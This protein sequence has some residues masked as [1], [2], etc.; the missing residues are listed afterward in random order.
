M[1]PS[2]AIDVT[3]VVPVWDAYVDDRL[4]RALESVRAQDHPSHLIVVDNASSTPI[5]VAD[6]IELLRL[7]QRV[8]VGAA[9]NAGCERAGT[10]W[11]VVWD[12]DD[13]MPPSALSRL[14]GQ[15]RRRPDAVAVFGSI[16][17]GGTGQRF[18]WP[19]DWT[20]RLTTHRG[21]FAFLNA[22]SSLYPTVG[23]LLARGPL[24]AGGGF[25]DVDTGDDWV[26]GASLCLRGP[27]VT[28]LDPTRLYLRHHDSVSS[29]WR[30]YPDLVRHGRLVCDRLRH[31]AATPRALRRALPAVRLLQYLVLF[32]VRP[33]SQ[34]TSR[35]RRREARWSGG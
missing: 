18:R 10:A 26:C 12:A 33:I 17:D 31:D 4:T 8:T 11:V 29:D 25:D 9:R 3:V 5:E 34:L 28:M 24:L 7:P 21:A 22:V 27:V 30:A 20:G 23:A 6:G 1:N 15:A 32:V 14:I 16:T 13:V 19:R 2:S 35:R